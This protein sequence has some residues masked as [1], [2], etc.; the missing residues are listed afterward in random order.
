MKDLQRMIFR[1][2]GEEAASGRRLIV[3]LKPLSLA[4]SPHYRIIIV[5]SPPK[6]LKP[7]STF[8]TELHKYNRYL[9]KI[10]FMEN[11]V[12]IIIRLF[13]KE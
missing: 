5:D 3:P 4:R 7:L 12:S 13:K 8:I 11:M 6:N 10:W 9:L 1:Y 2:A